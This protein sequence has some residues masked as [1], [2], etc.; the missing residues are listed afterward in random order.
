[1]VVAG[2]AADTSMVARGIGKPLKV[3]SSWSHSRA[4]KSECWDQGWSKHRLRFKP[5]LLSMKVLEVLWCS[6]A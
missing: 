3:C 2:A 4:G 5:V 6:A 1:M